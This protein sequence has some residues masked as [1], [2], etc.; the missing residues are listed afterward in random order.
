MSFQ[1][2][3]IDFVL[4]RSEAEEAHKLVLQYLVKLILDNDAV[5]QLNRHTVL[6]Q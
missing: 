3:L 4:W 2:H 5:F 1:T 6:S